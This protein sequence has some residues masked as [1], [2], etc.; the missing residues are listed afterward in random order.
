MRWWRYGVAVASTATAV[1]LTM[2]F[3][4]L[5]APMRLFF[6]WAAVLI[7]ALV[8]GVGPG[9]LAVALSAVAAAYLIFAPIGSPALND[10][11]DL[12]RLALF[13]VFAGSIAAAVGLR[14]R[15][16]R[17]ADEA[18]RW[19]STTLGSIGDGVIATDNAGRVVFM[20]PVSEQLTGWK[21]AEATGRELA[22]IFRIVNESTRATVESPVARVLSS[23]TVV[24]LANHTVLIARDGTEHPID[25]SAAPIA[26]ES[27][28]VAGVV[29]V[30][31][32]VSERR[33]LERARERAEQELR[34]SERRYRTLVEAT[35]LAQA[36]WT[37]TVDGEIHWSDDW[38]R[39]TGQTPEE[40]ASGGGMS[41]VHPDDA[42]RTSAGWRQAI[43]NA[44]PYEDELRVRVAGGRYRWFAIR[45]VPVRLDD[46]T[47]TEW[48]GVIADVHDRRRPEEEARFINRA[49]DLLTSTSLDY[50]ETLRTLAR[51]CVPELGD[52]CAI[53]VARDGAPYERL[54]VE[55][56]D[57]EKVKFAVELDRRFRAAP[58]VDPIARVMATREPQL[59]EDIPDALLRELTTSREEYELA[60]AL[61][62]R[63]W[64]IAPMIARGRTLGS[65]AVVGSE[66]GRRYSEEDLP[67]VLELARRAAL[68]VDNARL[69]REAED[70]S[71]AKDEFLATLSHE[72]RTPLT[73]IVGWASMMQ[74][75]A[76]D[77]E[78]T[79]IAIETILRSAKSQGELIDD[80]LDLS[81]VVAGKLNLNVTAV[82]LVRLT[83][84]AV[85]AARPAA[86]AKRLALTF[87]ANVPAALVRGDERR[88]QQ[89][90]WN[91]LTNAVKF[92]DSGSIGVTL[93]TSEHRARVQVADT[94]RGIEP[95]FLPHVWERFRQ[96][97]S[98]ASRQHGGLGLGLAVV[99][100]LVELHGGTVSARSG[101]A[102]RGA[103]FTIEL[104]L[105]TAESNDAPAATNRPASILAGSRVL[106]V[107][108]DADTRIVISTMLRR[109]GALVTLAASADEALR[110]FP[111][112]QPHVVLS[113]IAMPGQDGYSLLVR[114]RAHSAVPVIA[115][116]AISTTEDRARALQAGFAD[117][118]RKPVEP[119][120]LAETIARWV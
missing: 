105:A 64:I 119:Q 60:R 114:L 18:R 99:R 13:V 14:R 82:D 92:T 57:P 62:L 72:L 43:A 6:L 28:S 106:L 83:E 84:E 66:S 74:I 63:S 2:G 78:T 16:Q 116:S 50:E 94:G 8:G 38:M 100:H 9:F 31:H 1:A 88:L 81:R 52:W 11:L 32:D 55:H 49:T 77:A 30:F 40:L 118:L 48:V 107:D 54:V 29:L 37:A 61:G 104:P 113:D 53:D 111:E 71:R 101:G 110:I 75:G 97:D 7:S 44:R 51:L 42:Q 69:F 68:S 85:V 96:A 10:P 4:T 22:E 87:H 26:D 25:D 79:R 102:G 47:I 27:G 15:A 95:A 112:T 21:S 39:I 12:F 93:T 24:G 36:V 59:I 20:N 17:R 108:D 80:L 103:T 56:A 67:L 65:I 120:H 86:E 5:L 45:A 98:S 41:T 46:G 76:T 115:V 109:Y 35:P 3:P 33:T 90:I 89:V 23:G 70:A 58:E 19:L 34:V 73:A 117:F 91:L